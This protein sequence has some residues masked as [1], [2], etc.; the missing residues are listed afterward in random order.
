M[1]EWVR[2]LDRIRQFTRDDWRDVGAACRTLLTAQAMLW[3]RPSAEVNAWAHPPTFPMQAPERRILRVAWLVDAVGRRVF[4]M[5]CLARAYAVSRTL[6]QA[7]AACDVRIGVCTE[8][9]RL[10]A[11]AWVEWQG[12][13]LNESRSHLAR[14]APFDRPIGLTKFR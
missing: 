2:R 9:G 4:R 10:L 1:P 11:H 12:R 7:G 3:S 6:H 13:A 14:F 8:D 5:R